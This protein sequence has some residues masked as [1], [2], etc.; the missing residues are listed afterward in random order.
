MVIQFVIKAVLL[1]GTYREFR[2]IV[3]YIG[4]AFLTDIVRVFASSRVEI[5]NDI[6][7]TVRNNLTTPN[8]KTT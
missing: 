6:P 3:C 7:L 5:W 4:V 2:L 8:L 1:R